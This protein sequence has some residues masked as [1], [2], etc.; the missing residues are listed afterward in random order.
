VE[1]AGSSSDNDHEKQASTMGSRWVRLAIYIV[2]GIIGAL[3]SATM[4]HGWPSSQ[5]IMLYLAITPVLVL[6]T[7]LRS[8]LHKKDH[9]RRSQENIASETA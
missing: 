5:A 3:F 7:L 6:V 2:V 1:K 8:R 9:P 4:T